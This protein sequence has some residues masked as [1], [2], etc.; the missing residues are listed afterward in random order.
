MTFISKI[1]WKHVFHVL[2]SY[3]ESQGRTWHAYVI[4]FLRGSVQGAE[5]LNGFIEAEL[6]LWTLSLTGRFMCLTINLCQMRSCYWP[7]VWLVGVKCRLY[8][9]NIPRRIESLKLLSIHTIKT[10]DRISRRPEGRRVIG[11]KYYRIIHQILPFHSLHPTT[12]TCFRSSW[13]RASTALLRGRLNERWRNMYIKK[14]N[15]LDIMKKFLA[16]L[17][18]VATTP[19][20]F[21]QFCSAAS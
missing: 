9:T 13:C 14:C 21:R 18:T 12:Q 19:F 17:W 5:Y 1:N 10:G 3:S 4:E 2:Q 6:L 15:A 7:D 11:L 20:C 16:S 8:F